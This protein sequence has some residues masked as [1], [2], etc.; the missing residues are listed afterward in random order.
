MGEST[1]GDKGTLLVRFKPKP[2]LTDFACHLEIA[3]IKQLAHVSIISTDLNETARFDFG[4]LGLKSRFEFTKDGKLHGY[5]INIGHNTFIEVFQGDPGEVGNIN[6]LALE[7]EDIDGMIKRIQEH[8]YDVGEKELGADN[9]WQVWLEDPD[10]VRIEFHEYTDES[11][12]LQGGRCEV[13]W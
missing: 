8:G 13:S 4:A 9:S 2:L 11:L 6:H 3:V 10:G 12:Q 1:D 7:V 5:Y